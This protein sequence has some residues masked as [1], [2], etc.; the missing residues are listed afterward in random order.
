MADNDKATVLVVGAGAWGTALAMALARNGVQV[1]LWGRDPERQQEMQQARENEK[2]LPGVK[3]PAGLNLASRLPD[4]VG[5][6]VMAVPTKSLRSTLQ[7]LQEHITS[8]SSLCLTCKGLENDSLCMSH[9][10]TQQCLPGTDCTLLSGPSFAADVARERPTGV[11]IAAAATS[12][13]EQWSALFHSNRFRVYINNDM[14][15]VAIS[16]A[17][18]NVIAIA[19]GIA[20]GMQLGANSQAVLITRGLAEMS[21]LGIALGGK[22]ETFMGLAGIGDLVLSCSDDKSR[23]RRLGRLIAECGDVAT[24]K[25][26]L[27]ATTEGAGAV[28]PLLALASR[29]GVTMPISE[30]V[31]AILNGTT[32][33]TKAMD[34]LLSRFPKAE[35]R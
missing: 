35:Y 15:G 26:K 31:L 13:A 30:Q 19:A 33:P 20:A 8:Q 27:S 28:T 6:V 11:V 3:F 29:V 12:V 25:Q 7:Q 23:N 32:T 14:N 22:M 24:A 16:G 34:S 4:T 5:N 2:Y 10:V 9:E 1:Q 18:K 21:R 17:I